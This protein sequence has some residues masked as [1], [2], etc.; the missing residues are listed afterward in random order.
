[1]ATLSLDGRELEKAFALIVL[2]KSI[3]DL[4][5][6]GTDPRFASGYPRSYI[7]D[8]SIWIDVK[9][10]EAAQVYIL[11]NVNN[12]GTETTEPQSVIDGYAGSLDTPVWVDASPVIFV[13]DTDVTTIDTGVPLDGANGALR[14]DYSG[15]IDIHFV[16]TDRS[17]R[18]EEISEEITTIHYALES[19]EELDESGPGWSDGEDWNGCAF[20]NKDKNKIYLYLNE[21]LN[22][23]SV[24][25]PTEF[26]ISTGTISSVRLENYSSNYTMRSYIELTV[27]G[28][29]DIT[30]L[31]LGYTGNS[32]ED[33][34]GNAAQSFTNVAV[35]AAGIST[36]GGAIIGNDGRT[37]RFKLDGGLN[38]AQRNEDFL[39]AEGPTNYLWFGFSA[40]NG[41]SY[42]EEFYYYISYIWNM[43]NI[44]Y[45]I[46]LIDDIFPDDSAVTVNLNIEDYY[47]SIFDWAYDMI[48][49]TTSVTVTKNLT[50]EEIKP[51]NAQYDASTKKL[52]LTYDN[53]V[54]ER[55]WAVSDN[56]VL[57][58]DD[59]SY[60]LRGF[61]IAD[62]EGESN[63]IVIDLG[64]ENDAYLASI[65][66]ALG[67]AESITL[68]FAENHTEYMTTITDAGG[69]L[70]PS[71]GPVTVAVTPG[72]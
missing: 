66:T 50:G 46:S 52:T 65:A 21:R 37:V 20:I 64:V 3:S 32:I 72:D 51:T 57:T 68:S 63:K 7:K 43:T 47:T 62:V 5:V 28:I 70:L 56:F 69:S 53:Y 19:L 44:T 12:A 61:N 2:N 10:T 14:T 42:D 8:D 49:N 15:G 30:D 39:V 31:K 18:I 41:W 35:S 23:H 54:I 9:L 17:D 71:F 55:N 45:T 22:L 25:E 33:E 27:S 26:T 6:S 59:V 38:F 58:V 67:S 36:A 34:I 29:S 48:P 40:E 13:D 24:P 1:M 4:V 60:K 11:V 16:L